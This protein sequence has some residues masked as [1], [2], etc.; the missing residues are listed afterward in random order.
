MWLSVHSGIF[1]VQ[2]SIHKFSLMAKDQSHEHNNRQ[3]QAG[4]G[5]LS[6]LYDDTGSIALYLYVLV[7]PDS[8]IFIVAFESV[9]NHRNSSDVHHKKTLER[10]FV[11]DVASFMRVLILEC[12]PCSNWQ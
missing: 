10:R 12:C 2:W 11:N 1:F 8:V 7:A 3:V 5:G 4:G 6:D 9:Q